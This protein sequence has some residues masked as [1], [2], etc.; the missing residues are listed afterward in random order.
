MRRSRRK[1]FYTKAASNTRFI[2]IGEQAS[3][4]NLLDGLD[5]AAF[6][7]ASHVRSG[8]DITTGTV[9]DARIAALLAR[10]A[11]VFGIVTVADGATSGL[12]ADLLDGQSS[13]MFASSSRSR[14]ATT[15]RREPLTKRSSMC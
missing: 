15:S 13:E 5:S 1:I 4:S 12:D 7:A 10:D 9:A 2:N 11:E 6:A 3:N 14:A 8:D